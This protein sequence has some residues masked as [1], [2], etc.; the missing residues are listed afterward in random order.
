MTSLGGFGET[1]ARLT[2][3]QLQQ[4]LAEFPDDL[5]VAAIWGGGTAGGRVCAVQ[6]GLDPDENCP[7]ILLVVD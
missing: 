2:V 1:R 3:G 5:P 4:A 6:T 7:A